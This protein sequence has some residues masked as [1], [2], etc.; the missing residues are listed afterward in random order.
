MRMGGRGDSTKYV[1][2]ER[3]FLCYASKSKSCCVLQT[4]NSPRLIHCLLTDLREVQ[5]SRPIKV[6]RTYSFSDTVRLVKL[7]VISESRPAT[8]TR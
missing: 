7:V 2:D 8:C 1:Y 4:V 3:C 5:G 6:R